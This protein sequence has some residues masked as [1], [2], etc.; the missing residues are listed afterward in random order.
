M[1]KVLRIIMAQQNYLLGNIEGNAAKIISAAQHA[2][3]QMQ[4]DIIVFPELALTGYPPEDLLLRPELNRRVKAA[5]QTIQ[6]TVHEIHMVIGHPHRIDNDLYNTASVIYNDKVIAQ[7]HKKHLPNFGVFDEKR[8][9]K[10]GSQACVITIKKVPIAI[11]VCADLWYAGTLKQAINA[12]AKL[13][14]SINAS[15]FHIQKN[16][17]REQMLKQR[18]QEEGAIPLI[19]VNCVGGQDEL[20]F[21]GSSIAMD[22]NGQICCRAPAYS[23]ALVPVTINTSDLAM[24]T[25]TI[26]PPLDTQT[27]IY[28][29]LVLGTHDYIVKNN[30]PGILIG[31]SGGIDSALTLTIACDAIGSDKVHAVLMPSRFTAE[32]SIQDAKTLAENLNVKISVISIEPTYRAFLTSLADEFSGQAEDIT[33]ENIQARCRGIILMALSNKSGKLVLAT[34]NKSEMAVGYATLYGDMVGGFAVLKD[35]PKT[36][37]YQL[38][39]YRNKITPVIPAR[40]IERAPS[41][42]L[43]FNQTDQDLL[44]PY[45]ILDQIIEKYVEQ[46]QSIAKIVAQG[47]DQETVEKTVKRIDRNEY[48]RRQAAPGIRISARA[49]G[50]DWRYPITSGFGLYSDE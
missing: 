3:D 10:K 42:E 48:K 12:G 15:P 16:D 40:T 24:Q 26:P 25:E 41:A 36:L 28:Q 17:L 7:Y 8:Y 30:F 14:I 11:T 49:F 2:R 18:Q 22:P 50:R 6:N 43:A 29:A 31:L 32:I 37:V 23:E 4:A 5:L 45:E 34:G 35:I 19:Y 46:D 27:A 39:H 21:D 47:F 9:F 13:L 44:P 20:I 38:S 1:T 33:E